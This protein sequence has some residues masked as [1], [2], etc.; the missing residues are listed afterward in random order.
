VGFGGGRSGGLQP[1][2]HVI[3]EVNRLGQ[4]L[5]A[6]RVLGE[7]RNR[8]RAD[9]GAECDDE[10]RV[11]EPEDALVGLNLNAALAGVVG[12]NAAEHEVCVPAHRSEG[13]DGVPRFKR[14][15]CRFRQHRREEHEVLG[16]DDRRAAPPE[17]PCDVGTGKPAADDQRAAS[18]FLI[19]PH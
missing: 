7:A 12:E 16:A 10:I 15:G 2:Q 11:P 1:R 18:R 5:E 19:H 9:N 13:D 3:S 17:S 14:P 6:E 4:R 8:Q